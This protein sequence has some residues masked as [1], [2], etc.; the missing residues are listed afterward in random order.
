MLWPSSFLFYMRRRWT[1]EKEK[2][3]NKAS[4]VCWLL[5]FSSISS[6]RNNFNMLNDRRWNRKAITRHWKE[7]GMTLFSFLMRTVNTMYSLYCLILLSGEVGWDQK[8]WRESRPACHILKAAWQ[9]CKI[10]LFILCECCFY[11]VFI[12]GWKR[13]NLH[14]DA[15]WSR[16]GLFVLTTPAC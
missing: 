2:R 10:F 8:I 4:Y 1:K 12:I 3:M 16:F 5:L 13:G 15:V 11:F 14:S 6:R 7:L 9:F